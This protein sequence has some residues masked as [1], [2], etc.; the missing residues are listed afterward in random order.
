MLITKRIGCWM[1][2]TPRSPEH[3]S[4]R[5]HHRSLEKDV[6]YDRLTELNTN[7]SKQTLG[8]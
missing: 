8:L 1:N 7:A 4:L 6:S 3:A 2:Y 5:K